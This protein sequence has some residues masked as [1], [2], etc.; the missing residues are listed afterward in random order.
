MDELIFRQQK[1]RTKYLIIMTEKKNLIVD[2]KQSY[3]KL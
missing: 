1:Q 2:I 3:Y